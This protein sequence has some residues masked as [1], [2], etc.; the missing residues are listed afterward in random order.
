MKNNEY[1]R[2]WCARMTFGKEYRPFTF[3]TVFADSELEAERLLEAIWH[4]VCP[5]PVTT[6]AVIPGY[7]A[8]H[9]R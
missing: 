6:L 5:H 8:F 9:G 2:S 3:G 1:S 7:I 4:T